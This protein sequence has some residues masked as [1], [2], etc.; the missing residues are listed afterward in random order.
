MFSPT[1]STSIQASD[2]VARAAKR[3]TQMRGETRMTA[4]G[5]AANPATGP[6]GMAVMPA[7]NTTVTPEQMVMTVRHSRHPSTPIARPM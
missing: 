7:L 4:S 3:A 2:R 5:T 6:L 1:L